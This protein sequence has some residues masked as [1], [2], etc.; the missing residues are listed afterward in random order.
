[1][2]TGT[3]APILIGAVLLI[4]VLVGA[5]V[6]DEVTTT[7]AGSDAASEACDRALPGDGW[8]A[9]A[10]LSENLTGG[11]VACVHEN[12]STRAISASVNIK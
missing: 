5:T 3:P 9:N 6:V 8:H 10:S 11:R 2:N 7:I 12:G 1:M 4:G